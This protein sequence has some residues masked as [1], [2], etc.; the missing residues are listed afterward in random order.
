MEEAA[1]QPPPEWQPDWAR[2]VDAASTP[3]RSR[4]FTPVPGL[5]E[6]AERGE[7]AEPAALNEWGALRASHIL[8]AAET[9]MQPAEAAIWMHTRNVELG[10][11]TPHEA[12]GVSSQAVEACE[13]VLGIRD[14]VTLAK[15]R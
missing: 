4:Y 14:P 5:M 6:A 9:V 2:A 11:L 7:T 10:G 13:V 3:P 8:R 12:A 1:R 15:L